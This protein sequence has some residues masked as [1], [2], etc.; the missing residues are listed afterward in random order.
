MFQSDASQEL[1]RRYN[2]DPQVWK[3]SQRTTFPFTMTLNQ[4][5]GL[6]ALTPVIIY[7]V[8]TSE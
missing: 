1:T 2:M 7:L 5:V 6:S 8:P 3:E 4:V